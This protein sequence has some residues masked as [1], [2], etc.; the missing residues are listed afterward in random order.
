[1]LE[2][3]YIQTMLFTVLCICFMF[4]LV[5][6]IYSYRKENKLKSNRIFFALCISTCLW[7]IGFAFMLISPDIETANNW[8]IVSALGWCFFSGLWISFALSLNDIWHKK[9][10]LMVPAFLYI[11]S[12]IFFISNLIYEP[13]EIVG[14]QDYGF[15]DNLYP[16][17]TMGTIFKVYVGIL[18]SAGLVI[19]YFQIKNARKN[20]VRKQIKTILFTSFISICLVLVS[21]L[22][23]PSMGIMIYPI[24]II[25]ISI[26]MGGMWYAINKHKFMSIS[27][28]LVS[29]Y[30]FEAVNEPIFILGEDFFIQNCNKA[31]LNITGLN[32]QDLKEISLESI[33]DFSDF[34]FKSIMHKCSVTNIEVNLHS[35]NKEVLICELSAT[36]IFDEYKD[37]LGIIILLHDV[38]ERKKL[39]AIQKEYTLKLEEANSMLEN[40]MNE[41][42]LAENQ[43]RHFVYYDALTELSNRK[44]ML[45]EMELLIN[46]KNEKFAV[47]F[48]D[49]DK[50][51]SANDNY[52]HEAG[53]I[54]LKTVAL[55]LK[56]I[57]RSTDTISRIGGDEFIIILRNLQ[58]QIEAEKTAAAVLR[59]LSTVFP[60]KGHRLL[61]GASIGLS[62]FPE[63]GIDA[64]MLIKKADFAMYEVKHKGGNGYKIY[65]SKMKEALVVNIMTT[66]ETVL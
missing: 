54:V 47:L 3:N 59:M 65:S 52:G 18:F 66:M 61:I 1:M 12:L 64:D 8:R 50:F 39:G 11:T 49:L 30:L 27:Y 29:E 41:R 26:G 5:M 10:V 19:I 16:F 48:I 23:L 14:I 37:I 22:I 32:V 21:D 44:K 17:T 15:V 42:L 31:A 55:R 38:S 13:S 34:N 24:G 45:E 25:A 56:S 62:I 43:I 7:A 2:I 40:E 20:R 53:D 46:N 57:I 36:V 6:G 33:I 9:Y 35:E 58:D 4:Y 60:Y 51:K 63:H 28:E